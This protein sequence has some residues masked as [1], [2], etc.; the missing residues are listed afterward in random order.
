[1]GNLGV[2]SL[3]DK[4]IPYAEMLKSIKW[5]IK[6]NNGS[7]EEGTFM[8]GDRICI[9]DD[10]NSYSE[11]LKKILVGKFMYRKGETLTLADIKR[12]QLDFGSR[13]M[14]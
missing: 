1:M 13:L 3:V 2:H 5:A 12:W 4:N 10:A 11:V 9:N 6:G 7:R 8:R 14:A